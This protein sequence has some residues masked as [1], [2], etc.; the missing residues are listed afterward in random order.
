MKCWLRYISFLYIVI[1]EITSLSLNNQIDWWEAVGCT[2][3]YEDTER[4]ISRVKRISI[5]GNCNGCTLA[6]E[7]KTPSTL[8]SL[9]REDRTFASL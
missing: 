4:W 1:V 5:S 8:Q 7:E 3:A 2:S 9:T 6:V